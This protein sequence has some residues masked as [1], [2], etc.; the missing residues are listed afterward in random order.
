MLNKLNQVILTFYTTRFRFERNFK[1]IKNTQ[2]ALTNIK[3]VHNT[4]KANRLGD[5]II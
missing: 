3:L 5:K 4:F 2:G 1:E